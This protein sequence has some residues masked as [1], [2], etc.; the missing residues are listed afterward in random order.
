MAIVILIL[1]AIYFRFVLKIC[2]K[3]CGRSELIDS[4][5]QSLQSQWN[6]RLFINKLYLLI[7][8]IIIKSVALKNFKNHNSLA[9]DLPPAG[10]VASGFNGSGKSSILQGIMWV[11]GMT[12]PAEQILLIFP[13]EL[14]PQVDQL[15]G[16]TFS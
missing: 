8:K 6:I 5:L 9:V 16:V 12:I 3:T 14:S 15:F 2:V 10:I 4:R 1:F 7:K 13:I 11:L